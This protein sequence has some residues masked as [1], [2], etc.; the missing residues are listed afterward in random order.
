MGIWDLTHHCTG[1]MDLF[2]QIYNATETFTLNLQNAFL[3]PEGNDLCSICQNAFSANER[4]PHVLSC[5]H[6]LCSVCKGNYAP[7][8]YIQCETCAASVKPADA[9][10]NFQMIKTLEK[11]SLRDYSAEKIPLKRPT[12][13]NNGSGEGAISCCAIICGC[14]C[15]IFYLILMLFAVICYLAYRLILFFNGLVS[16][17]GFLAGCLAPVFQ[18]KAGSSVSYYSFFYQLDIEDQS[19]TEGDLTW[20]FWY[21]TN[22][23]SLGWLYGGFVMVSLAGFLLIIFISR[24]PYRTKTK[25]NFLG[26]L[27]SVIACSSLGFANS[28]RFPCFIQYTSIG[29]CDSFYGSYENIQ[30]G[31]SLG[32]Y[33]VIL[34]GVFCLLYMFLTCCYCNEKDD[35]AGSTGSLFRRN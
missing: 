35:H 19:Y 14:I 11:H 4:V 9:P 31:P 23:T 7:D 26:F 1:T 29:P 20:F 22:F 30:W 21:N 13:I 2:E 32:F 12:A 6:S 27:V 3:V 10:K 28:R 33:A 16:L 25:A 8:Q 15:G 5:G 18:I 17:V 34:S 24:F